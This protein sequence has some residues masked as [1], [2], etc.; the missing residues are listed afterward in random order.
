MRAGFYQVE[1]QTKGKD[2]EVLIVLCD[3][4]FQAEGF[5]I[6]ATSIVIYINETAFD[7]KN[8]HAFCEA[9]AISEDQITVQHLPY[10]NYNAEWEANFQPIL[11]EPHCAIRAKF[12]DVN[13][14]C[15]HEILIDPKMAF[16]T[17]HHP[18][19]HMMIKMMSQL[20]WKELEVFDYGAGT[21][22]LSVYAS[23]RGAKSVVANDIQ[24]ESIENIAEHWLL[25]NCKSAL[26]I[27]HGGIDRVPHTTFDIILANINTIVLTETAADIVSRLHRTSHLLLSGILR[28]KKNAI[29]SIY[30]A[31]GLKLITEDA[32]GDWTCLLLS[33]TD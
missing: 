10:R 4:F 15:A 26:S 9:N 3:P 13:H 29:L 14:T 20:S 25:N 5:E 7:K 17:G 24:D 16:G 8:I 31:L 19:T 22:I 33:R 27:L 23:K 21:G 28:E 2:P 12:H 6:K 18:T 11:I 32:M 30:T 1:I